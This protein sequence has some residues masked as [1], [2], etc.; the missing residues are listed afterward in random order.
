M[1]QLLELNRPE[2]DFP[3]DGSIVPVHRSIW[4]PFELE[5]LPVAPSTRLAAKKIVVIGG[6]AETY[7][8]LAG[9]LTRHRAEVFHFAPE[10]TDLGQAA[11]SFKSQTGSIDGIIDLN[12]AETGDRVSDMPWQSALGRTVALL[13]VYYE[14]WAT[15]TEATRLFYMPVTRLGGT[16]GFGEGQIIQPF[17]GIWAGLAKTLPRE[18]PNCNVRILDFSPEDYRELDQII[19]REL[20]RWGLFEIGYKAGK[21]FGLAC[22][23]AQAVVPEISLGSADTVLISGGGRGIGLALAKSLARNFNC[24][25]IVTGRHPLPSPDEPWLKLSEPEFKQYT[26]NLFKSLPPGKKIGA[27]RREVEQIKSHKELYDNLQQVAAEGLRVEYRTCDFKYPEQVEHLLAEIGPA[28]S[29]VIH[30][31][32]VDTPV[33]LPSKPTEVFVQTVETKLTGFMNLFTALKER[34]LKFFCN[35]GSLTGRWGGMVGQLDYASGNEG[36]SRLGLWAAQQVDYPLKTLCWPTWNRLGMIANFEATLK[37]MP[38]MDVE[39]GVYHWQ[40]EL[41]SGGSGEIC[42]NG[43]VGRALSPVY[44]RG[45]PVISEVPQAEKLYPQLFYTGE[46]SDFGIFH[47]IRAVSRLEPR[48][49]PGLYDFRI[50]NQ[51]ALPVSLLLEYALALGEWVAPEG[52]PTLYLTSISGLEV[53]LNSL[54]ISGENLEFEQTARG[55]WESG[56]WL[57]D[58]QL[59]RIG[60][61]GKTKLAQMTLVYSREQPP[62]P[63]PQ[64]L[65][66]AA[67]VQPLD[68]AVTPGYKWGGMVMKLASWQQSRSGSYYG[69]VAACEASDIWTALYLPHLRLP[70]AGFENILRVSLA[71]QSLAHP[72]RLSIRR[73]A[74]FPGAKLSLEVLQGDMRGEKWTIGASD[75]QTSLEIEGLAWQ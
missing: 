18:I 33:R 72:T 61:G 3:A 40:A 59:A 12:V 41:L 70:C 22:H 50:D 24:R 74:L 35:V 39:E 9:T 63:A 29:G 4:R 7:R 34:N 43:P 2:I 26:Q 38:A 21:R 65:T 68:L 36:L 28:L 49:T 60:V 13:K 66:Q 62:Q 67:N 8:Q 45:F 71:L 52:W 11:A 69:K 19:G 51:P 6:S 30:N 42:F 56:H 23:L 15:T 57:V 31:A 44:L 16:M 64:P 5:P 20:Y 75:G 25:V 73:I 17:G 58:M 27:V 47:F 54:A 46:V 53:T 1:T 32:G 14:E 37:Y 55:R 48:R 10:A